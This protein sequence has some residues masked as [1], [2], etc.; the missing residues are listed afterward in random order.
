MGNGIDHLDCVVIGAGVIGLAVARECALA[1]REVVVLEAEGTIGTQISS[2]NSEVIHAGIYYPS[3][4]L[5]ARMCVRGNALLYEYC[6]ERRIPHQRI[7]KVIIAASDEE[8]ATLEAYFQRAKDNGVADLKKVS[9][10]QM[11][12]LEPEIT[13]LAG[14]ASSSTGIIESHAL[15]LSLRAELEAVGGRVVCD[16]AVVGGSVDGGDVIL[17]MGGEDNYRVACSTVI[18][19]AGLTAHEVAGAIRGVRTDSIP[20]IHFALGHYFVL[21]GRSPFSRLIYPLADT[22]SL[23]IHVTLDLA[24]QV[25]FGP[26]VVWIERPGYGFHEN[27]KGDFVAAIRRYYPGLDPAR[28]HP[29][30]TG[31]RAKLAG[32]ADPPADF[33]IQTEREHGVVGLVNLFGIESPGLTS[34]L[35][36]AEEVRR[37]LS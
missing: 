29:G 28:L 24:G 37:V 17:E 31:V 36:L 12:R 18:N 33:V 8:C 21:S 35:A 32:P 4:S 20:Q 19:C 22:S 13:C 25:K 23:G 5:K 14:L 30:Y 11:R 16:T 3:G 15:M 26:D 9:R 10:E 6:R 27:R 1:G 2:H 34:C 7:G